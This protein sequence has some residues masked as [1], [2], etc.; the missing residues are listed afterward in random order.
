MFEYFSPIF[1]LV[2][3][4]DPITENG[5][6]FL[7]QYHAH[8]QDAKGFA[9]YLEKMARART[10]SGL[11]MRSANH[12]ERAVS[13]DEITGM[14]AS[15]SIF[16]TH[17]RHIIW[18]QLKENLGAYPAVVKDWTDR[19]PYNPGNYY[20]WGQYAESKM[21]YLFLFFY[22]INI[23]ITISKNK[24]DT[25][26]KLI[27]WLELNTMPINI[28]NKLLKKIFTCAMKKQYG[29][30]Y[31]YELRKIYFALEDVG[32]FPLFTVIK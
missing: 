24:N 26:S 17:H 25:S 1:G 9:I 22:F 5:G 4:A 12:K 15:S 32:E 14:M 7:A 8:K 29:D 23:I 31:I 11:Y 3:K 16:Q 18:N 13:H 30:N 27:Y 2:T 10:E 20:A 6:L 19:L 21:S 28:T